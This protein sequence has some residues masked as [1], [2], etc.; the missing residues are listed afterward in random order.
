MISR[1]LLIICVSAGVAANSLFA[2]TV[3][4]EPLQNNLVI[5]FAEP[6]DDF[7]VSPGHLD[8]LSA[9]TSFILVTNAPMGVEAPKKSDHFLLVGASARNSVCTETTFTVRGGRK[10]Y[11]YARWQAAG[12]GAANP[13][14]TLDLVPTSKSGEVRAYFRGQPL[15]S[16][17]ATLRTP[18]GKEQEITAD[19]EGFL[20]FKSNG[21]GQFLLTIAHHREALAGFYRGRPYQQTSHNAALT[22]VQPQLASCK[23]GLR[24]TVKSIL[25][26]RS[27]PRLSWTQEAI[28]QGRYEGRATGRYFRANGRCANQLLSPWRADTTG[29]ARPGACSSLAHSQKCNR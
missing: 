1:T 6:G 22:W 20:R 5:R 2:H 18:D 23:R 14:L 15:A 26:M 13:L 9:P 24:A 10:P 29:R 8:S 17:K 12:A 21:S 3:W 19:S 7:E 16:I 25:E 28:P 11:F 27:C 4:I